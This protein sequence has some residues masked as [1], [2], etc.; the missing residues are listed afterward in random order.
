MFLSLPE[1]FYYADCEGNEVPSKTLSSWHK[2]RYGFTA[3]FSL[4]PS[5]INAKGVALI[6]SRTLSCM[7]AGVK[8]LIQKRGW[9]HGVFSSLPKAF[10]YAAR[11]EWVYVLWN[12]PQHGCCG[13][14]PRDGFTACFSFPPSFIN[15]K[16]VALI[17]ARTL[18]YMDAAAKPPWMGLRRVLDWISAAPKMKA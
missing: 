9:L 7:G 12:L 18:S 16:G 4:P 5:F 17:K 2:R 13:R 8:P 10:C 14:A 1:A 3:C 11:R 15:A 6:Q